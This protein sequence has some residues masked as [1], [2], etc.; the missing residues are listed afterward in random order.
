MQFFISKKNE[1]LCRKLTIVFSV[2][3]IILTIAL[4]IGCIFI[5]TKEKPVEQTPTHQTTK[6]PD[7]VSKEALEKEFLKK[8]T[9]IAKR[10]QSLTNFLNKR[11]ISYIIN[12]EDEILTTEKTSSIITGFANYREIKKVFIDNRYT[13]AGITLESLMG[14][15]KETYSCCNKEDNIVCT[16]FVYENFV[17]CEENQE[18]GSTITTN[19][20]LTSKKSS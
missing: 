2:F 11:N 20:I 4:S 17:K 15:V 14:N 9:M 1:K 5:P 18:N 16:I 19:F 7:E 6:N 8:T 10:G 13:Q 3:L 12:K